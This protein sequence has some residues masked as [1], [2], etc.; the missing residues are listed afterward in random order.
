MF[1][2]FTFY[3]FIFSV[4]C[5]EMPNTNCFFFLQSCP[6]FWLLFDELEIGKR[7]SHCRLGELGQWC[8]MEGETSYV[9]F[10]HIFKGVS[11]SKHMCPMSTWMGIQSHNNTK[12]I[13]SL[14]AQCVIHSVQKVGIGNDITSINRVGVLW[15]G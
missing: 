7:R 13:Y 9:S 11:Y 15:V 12:A 14:S 1:H 4:M 6:C 3:L 10:K 2:L 5:L 8:F